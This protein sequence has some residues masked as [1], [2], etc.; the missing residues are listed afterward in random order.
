M[1]LGLVPM[2]MDEVPIVRVTENPVQRLVERA[3]RELF[4]NTDAPAAPL[5]LK[6]AAR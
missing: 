2:T 4:I 5:T 1:R 3:N 6:F